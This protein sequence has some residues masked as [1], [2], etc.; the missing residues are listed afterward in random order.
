MYNRPH[1]LY[2]NTIPQISQM[3]CIVNNT[4]TFPVVALMTGDA[5]TRITH[6]LEICNLNVTNE[7]ADQILEASEPCAHP[8]CEQMQVDIAV[9]LSVLVGILMVSYDVM[10]LCLSVSL[11]LSLSLHLSLTHTHTLSLPLSL[12]LCLSL[13]PFSLPPSLSLS[14]S[15]SF[16]PPPLTISSLEAHRCI[17]TIN[18]HTQT[19]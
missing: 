6:D 3:L 13:S 19:I 2:E 8:E 15:A 14:L 10:C 12:S 7:T 16:P 11:S 5:I 18:T 17:H 9:T 1:F 4:G